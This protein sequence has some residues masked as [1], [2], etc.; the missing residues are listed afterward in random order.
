MVLLSGCV[1]S[2]SDGGGKT[3]E[4]TMSSPPIDNS[5]AKERA[6]TAEESRTKSLLQDSDNLS[7]RTVYT[8]SA[9]VVKRN[10]SGILVEV[11]MG[12]GYQYNCGDGKTGHVDSYTQAKYFVTEENEKV[13]E[14][15][16]DVKLICD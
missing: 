3:T 10:S 15:S 8:K 11:R 6:T 13:I 1:G 9:R 14:R 4:E 2:I 7:D 5:T 16:S 12:Y